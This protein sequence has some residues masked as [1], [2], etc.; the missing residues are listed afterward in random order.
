MSIG[1]ARQAPRVQQIR[2]VGDDRVHSGIEQVPDD[3]PL[4]EAGDGREAVALA[5]ALRPDVCLFD[6][7]MPDV[8]GLEATWAL[9]GP[10]VEHPMADQ[11]GRSTVI[12]SRPCR[13][14]VDG[15]LIDVR[16]RAVPER[17]RPRTRLADIVTEVGVPDAGQRNPPVDVALIGVVA[18]SYQKL[19][20]PAIVTGGDSADEAAPQPVVPAPR[21]AGGRVDAL[22]RREAVSGRDHDRS[23]V[24]DARCRETGGAVP[25]PVGDHVT[26]DEGRIVTPLDVVPR[27]TLRQAR[28]SLHIGSCDDGRPG[29]HGRS[30][31]GKALAGASRPG[32]EPAA[33]RGANSGF[34][35]NDANGGY[36]QDGRNTVPL[37][38]GAASMVLYKDGH[39]DVVRWKGVTPG[40]EVAAV[41]QNLGLLV[42]HGVIT[43]DVNSTT[44][45]TWGATV[46]NAT[47]VWRSAVGIRKDGS[48]V[49]VVGASMSVKTLANIVHDAGAVRALAQRRR[50]DPR[51]R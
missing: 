18:G 24:T 8:N 35:M 23:P 21:R 43:P 25:V 51:S 10:D 32:G 5:R 28:R 15:L 42:D 22:P 29:G 7:R 46:G 41:R 20:I 45:S 14:P 11:P 30:G 27:G 17:G 31:V 39:V 40:P 19:V 13:F 44:T 4:V 33:R 50:Q 47:Y 1:H 36:W 16:G 34:T 37:R 9:A 38:N 2:T 26:A 3:E 49:F 48:L 6:I 12:T